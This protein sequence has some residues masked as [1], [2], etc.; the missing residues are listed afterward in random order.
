MPRINRLTYVNKY[1]KS[2]KK[3][4][5]R[6]FGRYGCPA[7]N[8]ATKII[9]RFGG[10]VR[11]AQAIGVSRITV[12]RWNYRRPYGTDGLIPTARIEE[13]KSVARLEGILLRPEDWTPEPN[14]WTPEE[15]AL[16]QASASVKPGLAD[17]LK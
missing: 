12:Y 14:N 16:S 8:Q 15:L 17:L 1:L 7:Y 13:I 5:P 10:E 11:L 3:P 6:N 2:E 9:A 4:R